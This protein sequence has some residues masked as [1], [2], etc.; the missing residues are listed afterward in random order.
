[1]NRLPKRNFFLI[2]AILIGLL[3]TG[4]G[5]GQLFGPTITPSPTPTLTPTLTPTITPSPTATLTPTATA[6]PTPSCSIDDGKWSGQGISFEILNCAIT[7]T[8][9]LITGGGQ[10]FGIFRYDEIAIVDNKFSFST[11]DGNGS[12]IFNGEFDSS[13]HAHGET[14][15]PKGYSI[16]T[17]TLTQ[18]ITFEW[19]ASPEK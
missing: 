7:S 5:P 19:E 17:S 1:M 8:T 11:P 13:V 15:L 9:Y 2:S 12:Y 4:C 6:T 14:T 3:S 18:D 10:F 16:G